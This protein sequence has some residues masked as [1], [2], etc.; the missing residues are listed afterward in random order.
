[1]EYLDA[2]SVILEHGCGRDDVPVSKACRSN[3][4]LGVLRPYVG[5]DEK[6]FIEVIEAIIS[7]SDHVDP[8]GGIE[9][10]LV[11]GV[12]YLCSKARQWGLDL[13]GMIQRN[14]LMGEDES[15]LLLLWVRCIEMA[16][17][18]LLS[19]GSPEEALRYY[20]DSKESL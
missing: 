16:F 12:V 4:F 13:N 17:L 2:L 3:G 10:K 20:F 11:F 19:G 8:K 1:M 9:V 5:L 18:E 6:N 14:G 15:G 7:L